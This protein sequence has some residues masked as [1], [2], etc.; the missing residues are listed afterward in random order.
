MLKMSPQGSEFESEAGVGGLPLTPEPILTQ[1][2]L[3]S[4]PNMVIIWAIVGAKKEGS[5]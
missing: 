3:K 4:G 5:K 2:D 1:I